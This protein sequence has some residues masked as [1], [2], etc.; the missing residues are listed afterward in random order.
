MTPKAL[1]E[2]TAPNMNAASTN[3]TKT[4]AQ[5]RMVTYARRREIGRESR[6]SRVPRCRSPAN[7]EVAKPTAKMPVRTSAIGWMKPR[8]MEPGSVKTLPPPNSAIASGMIPLSRSS[9]NVA[10]NCE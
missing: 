1:E 10:P 8:A 4:S 7:A 9:R 2:R 3:P 6:I 5:T